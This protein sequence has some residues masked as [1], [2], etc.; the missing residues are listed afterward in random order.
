MPSKPI[1]DPTAILW[2]KTVATPGRVLVDQNA[3]LFGTVTNPIWVNATLIATSNLS[4]GPTGVA[5]PA[6]ATQ[7]GGPDPGG[8]LTA[9]RVTTAAPI[10]GDPGLVVRQLGTVE[11]SAPG[12]GALATNAILTGGTV[13]AQV[14]GTGTAGVAAAGVM[15]VQGIAGGTAVPVSGSFGGALTNNNAAPAATNLGVLPALANTAAPAYTD[16]RQVLPSVDTTGATRVTGGQ[17][18]AATL[19]NVASSAVNVTLLAANTARKGVFIVND[20][21]KILYVKFGATASA[22]SY[23][24]QMP[25]NSYWEMPWPIYTGIID[26]IWSAAN[27]SARITET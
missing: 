19:T 12:G 2:D 7:I 14:A 24:V 6:D 27:G 8:L 18:A 15:T 1:L 3:A 25:A 11:V 16:G 21:N 26:G 20:G 5:V 23:T 10:V 22:T 17:T 4:V 9:P 13:L